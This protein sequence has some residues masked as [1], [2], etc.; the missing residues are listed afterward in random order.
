MNAEEAIDYLEKLAAKAEQYENGAPE[1]HGILA[2]AREFL[3]VY[4][5]NNSEFYN[6]AFFLDEKNPN[7]KALA[8]ILRNFQEYINDG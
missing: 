3:R 2:R 8:N 6:S 1:L 5:G 4:V 7:G